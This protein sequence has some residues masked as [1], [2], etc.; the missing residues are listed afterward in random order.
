MK[1]A[2]LSIYISL[3]LLVL[4]LLLGSALF[5]QSGG[6]SVQDTTTSLFMLSKPPGSGGGSVP[7]TSAYAALIKSYST[8]T[9]T[10]KKSGKGETKKKSEI[11]YYRINCY[12]CCLFQKVFNAQGAKVMLPPSA[13]ITDTKLR[14]KLR[15]MLKSQMS[16]ANEALK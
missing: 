3:V 2:T 8:T 15:E 5:A 6:G 14:S 12:N 16:L 13:R 9:Y 10:D 7:D 4:L 1:K 11:T